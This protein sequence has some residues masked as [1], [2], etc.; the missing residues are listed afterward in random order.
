M[1]SRRDFFRLLVGAALAPVAAKVAATQ[2][3][4][5]IGE[6]ATEAGIDAY[7]SKV[8]GRTPPL[9]RETFYEQILAPANKGR[10]IV[11][12]TRHH[13]SDLYHGAHYDRIIL[14][15]FVGHHGVTQQL[16]W[17]D[18]LRDARFGKPKP[19]KASR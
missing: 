8:T 14:D 15:D 2:E 13:E 17:N 3:T 6:R 12:G 4:P 11:V 7:W 18:V 10:C 16:P 19:I 5:I 9:S 1:T